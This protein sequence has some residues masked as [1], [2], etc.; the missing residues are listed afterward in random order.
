MSKKYTPRQ[1]QLID[2]AKKIEATV[3]RPPT[4]IE[5]ADALSLKV[6]AVDFHLYKL[7]KEDTHIAITPD[8][9]AA[10]RKNA[11]LGTKKPAPT[12]AKVV[13]PAPSVSAVDSETLI[14]AMQ[15]GVAAFVSRLRAGRS[16]RRPRHRSPRLPA[17]AASDEEAGEGDG[18]PEP[19]AVI[20]FRKFVV[21]MAASVSETVVEQAAEDPQRT[22]TPRSRKRVHEVRARTIGLRTL[23]RLPVVTQG[24]SE[25]EPEVEEG[26][27]IKRPTNRTECRDG[28]RPCPWVGCRH[29]L[30]LDVSSR[31]GIRMAFPDREPHELT[32][33]CS[34]D[35][36]DRGSATLEEVGAA[37]NVTRERVRQIEDKIKKKLAIEAP[38]LREFLEGLDNA[39][40]RRG[41]DWDKL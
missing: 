12:P 7:R 36:A 28:P 29:H 27:P 10:S 39:E 25:V 16:A 26:E 11:E 13:K 35:I 34:I 22:N 31:G 15:D 38:H 30:Y 40:D 21:E 33:S 1:Q 8:A 19:S 14:E 5:L 18:E 17:P 4:R 6:N 3:G 20:V 23:R 37:T 2:A 24:V 32:E 9:A 41:W